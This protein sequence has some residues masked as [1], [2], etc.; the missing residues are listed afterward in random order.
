MSNN[1][2]ALVLHGNQAKL[3]HCTKFHSA[4]YWFLLRYFETVCI[5]N[6]MHSHTRLWPTVVKRYIVCE[7]NPPTTNWI[8][9]RGTLMWISSVSFGLT[10]NK[11]LNKRWRY[12]W[13]E[14]TR[15]SRDVTVKVPIKQKCKKHKFKE[16]INHYF[17]DIRITLSHVMGKEI[18]FVN[19]RVIH[20]NFKYK[21]NV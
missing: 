4:I 17:L 2:L 20:Y 18:V 1:T 11:F 19:I 15:H 9:H 12:R 14:K 16:L 6:K 7:G 8:T 10:L 3:F 5:L 21:Q 13:F